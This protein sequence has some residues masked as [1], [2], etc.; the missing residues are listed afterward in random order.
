MLM[1]SSEG[2]MRTLLVSVEWPEDDQA[3]WGAARGIVVGEEE[4]CTSH[5]HRHMAHSG[6]AWHMSAVH[7][8]VSPVGN[9][10]NVGAL[11]G[12]NSLQ[13]NAMIRDWKVGVKSTKWLNK[14]SSLILLK[15]L[16]FLCSFQ[17]NNPPWLAAGSLV[18]FTLGLVIPTHCQ[19]ERSLEHIYTHQLWMSITAIN[20]HTFESEA[21]G[22]DHSGDVTGASVRSRLS[23]AHWNWAVTATPTTSYRAPAPVR[24]L[25]VGV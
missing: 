5:D 11:A 6:S 7:C 23:G 14:I 21:S 18:T 3:Q 20:N 12:V 13:C 1:L 2:D 15:C 25:T 17:Q 4:C 24:A 16:F 22:G 8:S 9:Q 19:L 10:A